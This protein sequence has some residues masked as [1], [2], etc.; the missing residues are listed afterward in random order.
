MIPRRLHAAERDET[1]R[2]A[3]LTL[4]K[5]VTRSAKGSRARSGRF[6]ELSR[7]QRQLFDQVAYQVHDEATLLTFTVSSMRDWLEPPL[8]EL[9]DDALRRHLDVLVARG[10]VKLVSRPAGEVTGSPIEEY[11]GTG[12]GNMYYLVC[13][14]TTDEQQSDLARMDE[15]ARLAQVTESWAKATGNWS[16]QRGSWSDE[17][18]E[19]RE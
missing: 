19:P 13:E 4:V 5:P 6:A 7:E 15:L 8:T 12:Y 2:S 3:G 14:Q 1:L 10:L 17:G 18:K 11:H 16:D 9:A